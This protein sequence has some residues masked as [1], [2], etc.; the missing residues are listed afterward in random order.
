MGTILFFFDDPSDHQAVE[1]LLRRAG[2]DVV[3]TGDIAYA[4]E[5][6]TGFTVDLMLLNVDSANGS[7]LRL[8]EAVRSDPELDDLPAVVCAPAHDADVLQLAR[9]LRAGALVFKHR[10][11]EQDLLDQISRHGS[12]PFLA[13]VP[14]RGAYNWTS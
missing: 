14:E 5:V 6:L 9:E 13:P 3:G 1:R 4:A 12:S 2:H 11:Y 8:L 7:S 10:G